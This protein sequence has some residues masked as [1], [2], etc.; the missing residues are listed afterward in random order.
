MLSICL[1]RS[2]RYVIHLD[3][4]S[5][6]WRSLTLHQWVGASR[7]M[8]NS[9]K[10]AR[11]PPPY[12]KLMLGKL[13][14]GQWYKVSLISCSSLMIGFKIRWYEQM[15]L[16]LRIYAK[17]YRLSSAW[18]WLS[19]GSTRIVDDSERH[20]GVAF[21]KSLRRIAKN[22][23]SASTYKLMDGLILSS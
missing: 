13:Q 16:C 1:R 6:R 4:L 7:V 2:T 19:T 18:L 23:S 10:T 9:W 5:L 20:F 17:L 22:S 14:F 8:T 3:S 12:S 15:L 11:P 21:F